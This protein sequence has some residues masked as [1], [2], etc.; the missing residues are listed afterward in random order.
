MR[1]LLTK[2]KRNNHENNY[3]IIFNTIFKY[4][5]RTKGFLGSSCAFNGKGFTYVPL[6][7]NE[8]AKA[9]TGSETLNDVN[10]LNQRFKSGQSQ[11]LTDTNALQICI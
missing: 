3:T 1:F 8:N 2:I 11:T 7:E 5:C 6:D 10:K 4:N 9:V